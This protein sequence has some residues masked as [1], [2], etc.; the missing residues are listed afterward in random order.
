MAIKGCDKKELSNL[1]HHSDRGVQYC[2]QGYVKLLQDN[3]IEIS[4]TE[5]DD[6][7]ENAIAERINGI[8]KNEYLFEKEINTLSKAQNE[9]RKAAD[10][11]NN[12]R[13][14]MSLGMLTPKQVHEQK[15]KPEKIWKNYCKKNPDIVN[16]MQDKH[17]PCKRM[18]VKEC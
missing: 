5:N 11:Y 3:G 17:Q 7:L 16:P 8:I 1:I 15:L 18:E 9:L 14:H 6:P 4:M 12:E 13:P 2:S 10:L